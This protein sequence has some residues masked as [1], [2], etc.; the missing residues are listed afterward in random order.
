M[1]YNGK[2]ASDR[3]YLRNLTD[4][5]C[6]ES[7]AAWLNDIEVNRYLET[8]FTVQTIAMIK[9]F[10]RTVNKSTD[11]C[12]FGI[13]V[14]NETAKHIGNIKIGPIHPIYEFADISYFIGDKT[15]W[16]LGYAKEAINLI[17]RF[18]FK[19]LKLRRIQAGVSSG[20]MGSAKALIHNGYQLEARL[21][22]KIF[23]GNDKQKLWDDHL[24]YGILREE[25]K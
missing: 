1:L 6:S 22:Q 11:S 15:V 17:T 16:G 9:D 10:V 7:Y 19:E 18:G 12:L 8:R 23:S 3:I 24:Y 21:R 25:L 2:P 4:E 14:N 13:F 20:N 5:D